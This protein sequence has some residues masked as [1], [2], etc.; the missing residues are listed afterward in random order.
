MWQYVDVLYWEDKS[1]QAE[2]S[3]YT[4]YV[5]Q[6]RAHQEIQNTK[7]LWTL[8]INNV[9]SAYQWGVQNPLKL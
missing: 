9:D 2:T 8:S 3:E 4:A 6:R 5:L 1:V 7:E